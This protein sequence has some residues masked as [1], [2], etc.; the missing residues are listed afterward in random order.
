VRSL[1][2]AAVDL[3]TKP[4]HGL[5]PRVFGV[6][7]APDCPS[8]RMHD[9]HGSQRVGHVGGFVHVQPRQAD[10]T[11][12]SRA[13]ISG[14]SPARQMVVLIAKRMVARDLVADAATARSYL[15]SP[16]WRRDPSAAA[17]VSEP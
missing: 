1:G 16:V 15:Q 10:G 3:V 6:F 4:F 11:P 5:V 9:V 12:V 2:G 8:S 7:N 13:L 17:Y 14:R